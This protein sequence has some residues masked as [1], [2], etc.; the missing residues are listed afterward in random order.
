MCKSAGTLVR[1]PDAGNLP[2]RFDERDLETEHSRAAA[3][4]LDS[5]RVVMRAVRDILTTRD[6]CG[7]VEAKFAAIYR[8][9]SRRFDWAGVCFLRSFDQRFLTARAAS[10]P[11]EVAPATIHATVAMHAGHMELLLPKRLCAI[12]RLWD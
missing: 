9:D 12:V 5:T 1:K 2:V 3:P 11:E 10:P 8:W 7:L 4:D 6:F